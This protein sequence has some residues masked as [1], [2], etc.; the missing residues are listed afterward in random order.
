MVATNTLNDAF[1]V[2]DTFTLAAISRGGLNTLYALQQAVGLQPGGLLPVIRRL[3]AHGLVA[4]SD[5]GEAPA[6]CDEGHG[7]GSR[8]A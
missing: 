6:A 3:Q 4:R 2:M 5:R 1:G 7:K 8:G